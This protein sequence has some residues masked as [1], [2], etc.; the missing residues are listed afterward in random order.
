MRSSPTVPRCHHMGKPFG[1]SGNSRALCAGPRCGESNLAADHRP[2]SREKY[3]SQ[4]VELVS[5]PQII[6]R[7][8]EHQVI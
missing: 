3:P 6:N 1:T 8:I 5:L 7:T 2:G 4:T